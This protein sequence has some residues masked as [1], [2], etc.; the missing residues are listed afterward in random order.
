MVYFPLGTISGSLDSSTRG[1]GKGGTK[2]KAKEVAIHKSTRE[3]HGGDRES[4]SADNNKGLWLC[5]PSFQDGQARILQGPPQVTTVT[6]CIR[7][8]QSFS[9]AFTCF[10]QPAFSVLSDGSGD[11]S[12]VARA[13]AAAAPAAP[14]AE[15]ARKRNKPILL[16]AR[17]GQIH[18]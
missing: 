4:D 12:T 10:W 17:R 2:E 7:T 18:V 14:M 15:A 3:K 13:L 5:W 16:S 8:F 6:T 9:S 11:S 1:E